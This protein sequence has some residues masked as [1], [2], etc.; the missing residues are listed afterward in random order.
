MFFKDKDELLNHLPEQ[1]PAYDNPNLSPYGNYLEMMVGCN[2][3]D[4]PYHFGWPLLKMI[5]ESK[6]QEIATH[7]FSHYYCLEEGQTLN[8]FKGDLH[9]AINIAKS[10]GIKIETIIFPRNQ[11]NEQYFDCCIE[12]GI[13]CFRNNELSWIYKARRYKGESLSRRFIRLADA[14]LKLTG[15]H[16]YTDSYMASSFPY[17]IPSSRFLRPFSSKL[18]WL[19]W[20]RLKRITSSMTYAAKNN[21]TY[22]LWWHPHNFGINQDENFAFLDKILNH[23]QSLHKKYGFISCNM[24][25]LSQRLKDSYGK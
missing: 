21:L 1:M 16:C 12:A 23:Y 19:D 17:N 7:T 6:G 11:V 10:R 4:D 24:S 15:N 13:N 8:D 2:H 5:N 20:L 9:S 14:Y 25:E 18:K 22:H 3:E